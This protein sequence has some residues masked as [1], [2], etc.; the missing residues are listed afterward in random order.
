MHDLS[1]EPPR[2]L[3]IFPPVVHFWSH[4]SCCLSLWMDVPNTKLSGICRGVVGALDGPK[5]KST[6]KQNSFSK[7]IKKLLATYHNIVSF[8][9]SLLLHLAFTTRS[10]SSRSSLTHTNRFLGFRNSTSGRLL[11]P[12]TSAGSMYSNSMDDDQPSV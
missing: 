4:V 6:K 1:V 2:C 3:E 7:G 11:S 10:P 5:F 12:L 8:F 9:V